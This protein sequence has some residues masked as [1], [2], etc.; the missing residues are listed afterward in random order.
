MQT[1]QILVIVGFFGLIIFLWVRP[2]KAYV[3]K[4][5]TAEELAAQAQYEA[6]I[7]QL[8]ILEDQL[9]A[10]PIGILQTQINALKT[11]LGLTNTNN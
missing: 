5:P 3:P 6:E 11:K 4:P 10:S 7:A 2:K 1:W 9:A 8:K